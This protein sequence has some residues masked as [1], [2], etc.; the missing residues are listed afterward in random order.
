VLVVTHQNWRCLHTSLFRLIHNDSCV[1]HY[2]KQ[3]FLNFFLGNSLEFN[4][5][6]TTR[7]KYGDFSRDKSLVYKWLGVVYNDL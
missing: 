2:F 3:I 7:E 6:N 1:K 5:F 4:S